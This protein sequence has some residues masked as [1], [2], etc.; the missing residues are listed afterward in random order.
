MYKVR[1]GALGPW[2]CALTF[3]F[4]LKPYTHTH[5]ERRLSV[6]SIVINSSSCGFLDLAHPRAAEFSLKKEKVMYGSPSR[7]GSYLQRFEPPRRYVV[8][9]YHTYYRT[10]H[11]SSRTVKYVIV[12]AKSKAVVK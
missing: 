9:F 4:H 8:L 1:A 3:V 5:T 2:R 6:Y 10:V 7:S 12:K 11:Q